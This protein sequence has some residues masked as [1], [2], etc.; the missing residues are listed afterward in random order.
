MREKN[1]MERQEGRAR[2]KMERDELRRLEKEGLIPT[3]FGKDQREELKLAAKL[4]VDK[5]W[6]NSLPEAERLL[7]EIDKKLGAL[8]AA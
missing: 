1:D 7:D 3:K 4:N 5:K 8:A 2:R 6:Q